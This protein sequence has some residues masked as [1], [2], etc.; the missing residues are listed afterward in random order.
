M[1]MIV[2]KFQAAFD[3]M[4]EVDKPYETYFLKKENNNKI[5]GLPGLE[6]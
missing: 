4:A 5:V 2:L 1:L 6:D 3:I